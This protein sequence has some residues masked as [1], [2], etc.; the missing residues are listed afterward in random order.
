MRFFFASTSPEKIITQ[1]YNPLKLYS[2]E[3][4]S[5]VAPILV[6]CLDRK[7]EMGYE[8]TQSKCFSFAF[9]YLL[10]TVYPF[11]VLFTLILAIHSNDHLLLC[12][13]KRAIE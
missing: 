8:S 2:T 11:F 3:H 12:D 9:V 7:P 10:K 1:V 13:D 5:Q 6:P 4:V